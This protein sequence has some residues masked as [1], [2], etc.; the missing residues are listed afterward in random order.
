MSDTPPEASFWSKIKPAHW[1][2]LILVVVV[3]LF[4]TQ[5]REP[6][7]I[8]LFWANVS[9]PLWLILTLIFGI[10]WLSGYLATRRRTKA[11]QAAQS[12]RRK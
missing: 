9:A 4:V 12:Q 10:G 1:I 11:K 8:S 3:I 5:N 2:A 6:V 7:S